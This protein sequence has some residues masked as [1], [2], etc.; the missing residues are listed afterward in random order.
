[1]SVLLESRNAQCK[2][3]KKKNQKELYAV[4]NQQCYV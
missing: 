4:K 1:M 3:K 2:K